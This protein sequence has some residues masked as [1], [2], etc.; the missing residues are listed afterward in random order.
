MAGADAGETQS[1]HLERLLTIK[2]TIGAE[3][4]AASSEGEPMLLGVCFSK[5]SVQI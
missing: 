3:A 4:P 1:V 2:D 5:T